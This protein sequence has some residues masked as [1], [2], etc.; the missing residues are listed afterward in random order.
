M[1]HNPSTINHSPST[2]G[3]VGAGLMGRMLGV[4][5]ARKGWTVTLFDRDKA[6][7]AESCTW[8]SAGMVAPS[9]E[10][11]SA[12]PDVAAL[13]LTSLA[14]WPQWVKD[15]DG[16]IFF[17]MEGSVVVAHPNDAHELD[18]LRQRVQRGSDHPE[19]MEELDVQSLRE[20]EPELNTTFHSGLYMKQEGHL[21]NRDVMRA[22]EQTLRNLG[23]TWHE[24]TQVTRV[25]PNQVHSNQ[26]NWSFDWVADCRGLGAQDDL[27]ELRGVRGELVHLDAP[28]VNLRHPVRLM[29]P[30]YPIYVVPRANHRYVVG[31]TAIESEDLGPISVRSTLEL[32][33]AAYTLH[34]GFAEARVLETVT[35]CRP[36][37][38]NHRPKMLTEKGL[39]RING[40]YRHGFLLAPAL[41]D[42]ACTWLESGKVLPEGEAIIKEAVT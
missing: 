23:V 34:T 21:D 12:E 7:G 38:R 42:I 36:A 24:S 33:S 28:E 16:D 5:L 1:T 6:L 9:C 17:E 20:L 25:E 15:L 13:G 30:R 22:A 32:L 11:E 19:F 10:L 18:R 14:R 40:L 35:Q 3:I 27:P 2:I 4:A 37:F 29:H 31:A 39:V 26:E 41:T 8:A